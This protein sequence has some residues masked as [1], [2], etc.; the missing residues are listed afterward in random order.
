MNHQNNTV[1]G[2]ENKPQ[3]T[4][5][6][7]RKR[8]TQHSLIS[9]ATAILCATSF[10]TFAENASTFPS[11]P[12]R[13]I[14]PYAAGGGTDAF[15]R[16]VAESLTKHADQAVIVENKPGAA[17]LLAGATVA[18]AA[19]DGYTLLIDQS[20]IAYQP[21]LHP[22][23]TFDVQTDLQPVILGATLDNV[24]LVTPNFPAK[25]VDDM[26][27]L[28]RSKPGTFNY[29]STGIG[30]PQHL[31]MEVLKKDA[32]GLHIQHVPYKGGNPG[33]VATS[34]GEVDMFFIS[35]S[36]ALPFIEAGRVRALANG[37]T[38]R[39][40]MLPTLPTFS[41]SKLHDFQATGW[42]AFFAPAQTPAPI[43]AK[44][45][46]LLEK[47]LHNESTRSAAAKQGFIVA[48]GTPDQLK[49]LLSDDL[50]RYRPVIVEL[51]LAEK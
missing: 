23:A 41:E 10:V 22:K 33:I 28:V 5:T 51:G 30:T 42:L 11:K 4:K 8:I 25:T 3:H 35:E 20:S 12:I 44:L 2:L 46:G 7:S 17:G 39:S 45:N 48:G 24:L 19:P 6:H 26:I 40:S 14:V 9:A 37:G 27:E 21:V 13:L 15:A 16:M 38:K 47:A 1:E 43:I 34:T 49:K 31:A 29:A 32:G 36:T 18:N 50:E